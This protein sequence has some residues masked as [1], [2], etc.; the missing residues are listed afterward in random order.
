MVSFLTIVL[1]TIANQ[2]TKTWI[3]LYA[4]WYAIFR[5]EFLQIVHSRNNNAAFGMFQDYSFVLTVLALLVVFIILLFSPLFWRR[6][7]IFG[8]LSGSPALGLCLDLGGTIGNLINRLRFGSVTNFIDFR[9]WP[10]F[11]VT[12]ATATVSAN[13]FTYSLLFLANLLNNNFSS[14]SSSRK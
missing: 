14:L 4:E 10:S 13:L 2:L 9:V 8:N 7:T 12:D 3:W 11:N 1:V 5:T 6:L